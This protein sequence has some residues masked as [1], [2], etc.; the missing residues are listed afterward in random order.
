MSREVEVLDGDVIV[1]Y[2][3]GL[4]EARA[5]DS[6]FGEERVAGILRRDPGLDAQT[7]CK[8]LRDAAREF[9]SQPFGDDVA[10]LAVR[11]R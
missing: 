6:M 9:S 3:D 4:S 1:L 10:I 5:G 7:L 11:R 8:T 2:T